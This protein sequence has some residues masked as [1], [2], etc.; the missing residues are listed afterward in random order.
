M[1]DETEA[2]VDQAKITRDH[3]LKWIFFVLLYGAGY[4][5]LLGETDFPDSFGFKFDHGNTGVFKEYWYS[6]LLLQ[7]HRPWDIALFAWLWGSAL[8]FVWYLRSRAKKVDAK[9]RDENTSKDVSL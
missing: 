9:L 7:R 2:E 8:A 6:Y 3:D 4:L 5:W 1:A